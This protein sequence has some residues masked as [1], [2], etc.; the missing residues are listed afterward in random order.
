MTFIVVRLW[1]VGDTAGMP[2]IDQSVRSNAAIAKTDQRENPDLSII[3]DPEVVAASFREV[4]GPQ[5]RKRMLGGTQ[6]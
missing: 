2:G 6:L 1:S 5:A 3:L 4:L